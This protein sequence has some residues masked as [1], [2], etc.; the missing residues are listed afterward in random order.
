MNARETRDRPGLR[1]VA[2]TLDRE[3]ANATDLTRPD[4][5]PAFMLRLK[6][7]LAHAEFFIRGFEGDP[8]Q[9][10]IDDLRSDIRA[11]LSSLE[12]SA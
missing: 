1:D 12:R 7:T 2:E 6:T 11:D 10:G 3:P 5:D 9:S 4:M 8:L